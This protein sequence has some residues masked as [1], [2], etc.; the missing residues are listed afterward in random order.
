MCHNQCSNQWARREKG[1]GWDYQVSTNTA[2]KKNSYEIG[3]NAPI[4][5]KYIVSSLWLKNNT[6]ISR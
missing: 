6:K 4:K 5:T 3:L 2:M 1:G